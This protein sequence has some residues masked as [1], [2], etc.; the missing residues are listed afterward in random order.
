[1]WP[2]STALNIETGMETEP[3]ALSGAG[4]YRSKT[5]PSLLHISAQDS[6]TLKRLGPQPSVWAGK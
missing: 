2:C 6:P 4:S 3:Q 1:M 5:S